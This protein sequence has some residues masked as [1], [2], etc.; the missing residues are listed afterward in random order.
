LAVLSTHLVQVSFV[1][2][3]LIV[4]YRCYFCDS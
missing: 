2:Y 3:S 4:L 1:G